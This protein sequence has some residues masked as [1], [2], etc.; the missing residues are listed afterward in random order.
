MAKLFKTLSL[1]DRWKASVYSNGPI[2]PT[3]VVQGSTDIKLQ[4]PSKDSILPLLRKM[5]Q[6]VEKMSDA[7]KITLATSP[8]ALQTL[9]PFNTNFIT[10]FAIPLTNTKFRSAISLA[11]RLAQP[12]FGS[13]THLAQYFLADQYTDYITITPFG[14]FN[15]TS[16]TPIQPISFV[17]QHGGNNPT[18]I[19]F[20]ALLNQGASY[21]NGLYFSNTV[22]NIPSYNTILLQGAILSNNV[23]SSV[24][25]I[26]LV[27]G[28]DNFII[29]P[30]IIVSD[31]L[32]L[33]LVGFAQGIVLDSLGQLVST[34]IPN[35]VPSSETITF[36]QGV[37]TT[38]TNEIASFITTQAVVVTPPQGGLNP[39]P[40]TFVVDSKSQTPILDVLFYEAQRALAFFAP[41][42]IHGSSNLTT[43][44]TKP[45]YFQNST[46]YFDY[47]NPNIDRNLGLLR[48]PG[49]E[50]DIKYLTL[51]TK[52]FQNV[53]ELFA[54]EYKAIV[55]AAANVMRVPGAEDLAAAKPGAMKGVLEPKKIQEWNKGKRSDNGGLGTDAVIVSAME[56]GGEEELMRLVPKVF[57]ES[58]TRRE[59]DGEKP[60]AIGGQAFGSLASY[61]T[62]TYQEITERSKQ[63]GKLTDFRLLLTNLKGGNNKPIVLKGG[64]E[65]SERGVLPKSTADDFITLSIKS[66]RTDK[67][68]NFRAFITSFGDSVNVS[69]NDIN[70][71]GRQ[72]TLKAFKGSTRGGSIAFKVAALC[73]EDMATNYSK[74]NTLVTYA[75]V[76]TVGATDTYIKGPLCA[77][78]VGAWF[79][80]T[81]VVFNSIKFDIQM[82]EYSW[83][84][85]KKVPQI[86]D[87]S[88]D[89]VVLGDVAGKPIGTADYF[90]YKG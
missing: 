12:N 15:H 82:A 60:K 80:N 35:T 74:L 71:V 2:T 53:I 28:A 37:Y 29:N 50:L 32:S 43:A 21:S 69:W 11:D 54:Q 20:D 14:V 87:V 31:V 79:S 89:F 67:S 68:I 49:T 18:T 62:L 61:S 59:G 10:S 75:G 63:T 52:D 39:T 33:S 40:I 17:P 47:T 41:R 70:Y 8:Q 65:V 22:I 88:L 16:N 77:L 78:T 38:M 26:T 23:Y 1:E 64:K 56:K 19:T 7:L 55:T 73:E 57:D 45:G 24:T 9:K 58:V 3:Q 84:I 5:P 81:P 66:L 13:T 34:I 44:E 25:N 36:A 4:T 76:G 51:R 86:V 72:D 83:D 90:G 30:N 6:P 27:P 48:T 85:D 42:I 46:T